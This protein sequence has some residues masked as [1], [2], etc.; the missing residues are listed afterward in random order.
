MQ[1]PHKLKLKEF[2]LITSA[3]FFFLFQASAQ[4]NTVEFGKNRLQFKHM[5]WKYY[6]TQNFNTYFNQN[7]DPLAKYV[8]QIAEKE[9]PN[10]EQQVEYGL[11]RRGNI[12]LYN[13]FNEMEQSNIGLAGDWQ[14]V[15]GTTKLVN[16]KMIVYYTDDHNKLRV[17]VRQ[18]IAKVLLENILFGDDLGEFAANQTLLD[19]PQWMTDGYVDYIAENWNTELDDQLKSAI[20][21]DR[22]SNFYNLAFEKPELAGHAF[23]Y[24]FANRYKKENVTYFLYLARVYRNTNTAA[25]RICK[26]KF[27]DVLKDFM[28]EEGEIYNK[29][30]HGRRNFPK[31]IISVVEEVNDNKDFF[32]FSP[33]PVPR[34]Q[35]YAV[36][37][38][39]HGQY[40]VVLHE[41]YVNRKVL[42]KSGVRTNDK[43]LQPHY[44][45]I[46]WDPKGTRLAVIYYKEGKINLFVYDIVS[47]YKRTV[48]IL[49]QFDQI[50]DMKYM[51]DNN[52]LL[53]S[54]VKGGQSDIFVYNLG[55]G[56]AEQITNDVWD[57]RDASFASFPGKTGII[58]SSNRPSGWAVTSDTVLPSNNHYNI[59]MVDNWNKSDFKQISQLTHMKYGDAW[60]PAQY[61]N[62]HFTFISDESGISNRYAGFFTTRRAGI[63]T[64]YKIGDELLHNPDQLELDSTLRANKETEPDSIYTFSITRDSAYVFALTNYQSGL[65]ETKIAGENG[66]VSEVRQEGD[67]KFLYKLKVDESA[68]K[69]RNINPRQTE[70]RKQTVLADQVA[71]GNA[72]QYLTKKKG[73]TVKAAPVQFESEFE[74]EAKDTVTAQQISKQ[75]AYEPEPILKQAKLFDYK[76]KFS[77]ESF[78][79]GFNNDVLV[80]KYQPFTGSLPIQLGGN[81]AFNA[82]FK[83]AVYDLFE[84]IRFTGALRLP[85]FGST[86]TAV[87]IGSGGTSVGVFNPGS[88]SFFNGGGEWYARFDYLKLRTD[89]SLVYYRSTDVGTTGPIIDTT[90]S[91]Y[92]YFDSKQFTNLFQAIIRYPFDK[93]RSLRYSVGV[94]TDKVVVKPSG[95]SGYTGYAYYDTLALKLGP[96]AKQTFLL[97]HIEYVY[98]NTVLKTTNI[99]NGTRYKF[100]V[101][102]NYQINQPTTGEG[103]KMFNFGFDARNYYPIFRNFIWALRAAG[104][105]SWGNQKIVYYLGGQDGWMFPQANQQPAP[106]YTQDY[107]YQSLAVNLRGYRQNVANGNN[108]M[109]INS[110]LRLPIFTTLMSQPINSA[111]IRNFQL[112]Q[113][114]DLGTAWA[115]TLHN[116]QRPQSVY[117]NDD[118]S[119]PVSVTI[120]TGGIGP[121][122]G[123]YGFGIRSTLLGYFLRLDAGW[124]MNTFFGTK[125]IWQFAMG[126]DF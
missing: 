95:S 77:A 69:K 27:K 68:L 124:Q 62:F 80:N 63:D 54:A 73:D 71:S 103:R 13:S 20:L 56:N 47:K 93:V 28:E 5:K 98:D 30:I 22:Y 123:G 21:S 92:D 24:Y 43:M 17:Q 107:A 55:T 67:L 91:T 2:F 83:A 102:F 116:I 61:N 85:L 49:D 87:G 50:Q 82:M 74:K 38:Y 70:Y 99:W 23:W 118:P 37:E 115:G 18:G 53:M 36:V 113:F 112:I 66:Q 10:I 104:D 15:G 81:E 96:I 11:Q 90:T 57:D 19:L 31:G 7:G 45:L 42:F 105:F 117:T 111:F 39:K 3:L 106:D 122:A 58:Y 26:K 86:N 25:L 120:K 88:G 65:S 46:A 79:A 16:N 75:T 44:P 126:V 59:F 84:D 4:V 1:D 100:Y 34:S 125:A 6:Q 72:M 60:F 114:I 33:N 108:A 119:V 89:F 41:N 14:S 76:L 109:I 9:L 35:T 64:V 51:L 94:R 48:T 97:N 12:V 32:H 52:T 8:A 101:D 78:T 29:D 40:A 121:F 110:E